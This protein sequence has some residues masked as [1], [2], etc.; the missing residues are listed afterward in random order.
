MVFY[1]KYS[2]FFELEKSPTFQ[3]STAA[4]AKA[5]ISDNFDDGVWIAC[6]QEP[7]KKNE[8]FRIRI[9]LKSIATP[10]SFQVNPTIAA[11]DFQVDID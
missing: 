5:H 11:G 7:P 9:A 10:D 4:K 6:A 8:D 3:F 1:L 2:N